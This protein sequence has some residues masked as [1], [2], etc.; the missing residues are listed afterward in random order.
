MSSSEATAGASTFEEALR[1]IDGVE[2]WLSEGQARMLWDCARE[3]R[4]PGR[5]V[6][7]GS[8]RGRS[9]IVLASAAAPG[10]ELVSID[11]HGGSDRGPQE[12]AADA[13]RGDADN[14][15]FESNL[16]RAG[17]R[18]R[19]RHVRM[20]AREAVGEVAGDI[21]LLYIDGAHR[22][23]PVREDIELWGARVAPA[24]TMLMHDAFNAIGVTLA[25][26]R[27]LLLSSTWRY[28]GRER[29]LARYRRAHLDARARARNAL[30]QLG[31]LPYFVRNLVV[32]VLIVAKLRSLAALLG[33]RED[34]PY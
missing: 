29:S 6:E 26:L 2:G 27:L 32:K 28:Q 19:V 10:V 13:R 22:Y 30:G 16:S 20:F 15:A 14:D 23:Q 12:I 33:C 17:V 18:D 9:M 5:I 34:W 21:D 8:F 3:V 25:Q 1:L 31:G 4:A 24:G 11:P 7:I